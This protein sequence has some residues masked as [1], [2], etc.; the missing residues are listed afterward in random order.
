MRLETG[1]LAVGNMKVDLLAYWA[2]KVIIDAH[3]IA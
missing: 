2:W 3:N 1:Y